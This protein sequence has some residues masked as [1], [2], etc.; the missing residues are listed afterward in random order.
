MKLHKIGLAVIGAIFLFGSYIFAQTSTGSIS[1][2]VEDESGA[3]VP[4]ANVIIKNV[5]T[6]ISR[7]AVTDAAG[8]YRV[9]G[10][11]PDHYEVQVTSE[12]F[13][14]AIR[15]GLQ[16]TVGS[17]LEINIVLKVGQV[18]QT[19]VVTAEASLVETMTGT[20]SGLVDDKAVRDLP[21]NG[22]SF[23]QL[24]GLQSSA[25][26][27]RLSAKT[28]ALG[29][30]MTTYSVNGAREQANSFFM[31]GTEVVGAGSITSLPGGALGINMGVDA[32]QEFSVLSSTYSAVY[33]KKSGGVI[34]I[35]TRSGSNQLHGSA[36]EFLRNSDLDARNFFD[37]K[38]PS[39][40]QNQ[41]GG[42]LG[43]P[44]RKDQTFYFGAYEGLRE[45][46]GQTN[47]EIVPDNNARQGLLPDLAHP[48]QFLNVGV[49]P[50][51]KPYLILF[52]PVN[53]R[54]FGD[55][56]AESIT[57][58]TL[59]SNQDFYL[60]RMDHRISDRDSLFGRYN[61][62]KSDQNLI[63]NILLFAAPSV[64]S[65]HLLT[66]QESRSYAT[67]LN[68]VRFGFN[69]S[70]TLLTAAPT[71]PTDPSLAFIPGAGGIGGINFSAINSG[72]G[73]GANGSLTTQG[74]G[75]AV[76]RY[77]TFNQ[78][79]YGDQ[80]F[81]QVGSHSLQLGVQIQRIQE[82]GAF[83]SSLWGV[84][85]FADLQTFLAGKPNLFTAASPYGG[86]PTKGYRLTYTGAYFQDDYKVLRN[87]TL[88]LGLRYEFLTPPT[89][90]SGNRISNFHSHIVNGLPVVDSTPTL[91]SPFYDS[92]RLNF[93]P[94]IGFAWDI[95]GDS[96]TA[97][98]GG[99]GTF[100]DQILNEF[101]NFTPNN[102]P[103]FG[104]LQVDNP[105]FPR[106]FSGATGQTPVPSVDTMDPHLAVPTLMGYNLNVQ[107]QITSSTAVTIGYVGSRGYHLTRYSELNTPRPQ[108][109]PGN[110]R[111]Y[112]S[113]APR[114]NPA[115]GA[116]RNVT[117]DA[118]SSY[119]SLQLEVT[120]HLSHG[121][122]YKVSLTYAKSIDSAS[123]LYTLHATGA[124]PSTQQ[125][126]ALNL[127]RGLSSFN[128]RRNLVMNWTYD[129]PWQQSSRA[130]ARW[131]GGWQLSGIVTLSD[132]MPFTALDGIN[133]SGDKA[134]NSAD[135]PNLKPGSSNNPVLG[136][137]D[138]YFD[139]SSFVIPP[140]GFY[141]NLGRNT[142]ISPG[143]ATFDCTLV[144]LMPVSE[145][146]KLDF[147]AEF[148]NLLNK[149]NFGLPR[150]TIFSGNGQAVAS[151]GRIGS[152]VS[153][154][155]QIQ[156]GL[157]LLF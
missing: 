67:T 79:E 85:Q 5:E 19:T 143:F 125:P 42:A 37:Q 128:V 144:K 116:N 129:L 27:V 24:I 87:L 82:N 65:S 108:I 154:S 63:S 133:R 97:V 104:L 91:G 39:F 71:I 106:G 43:G 48:G 34:N 148:F 83:P 78:F 107:R 73:A 130:M 21:L 152:T 95:F 13:E 20:L 50:Q 136:G 9:P 84:F 2:L 103:F 7:A 72:N 45:R 54:S 75:Q 69:R 35:A 46:L 149:A 76:G 111:F 110:V 36:F 140:V 132:G 96:K 17:D 153:T 26:V 93:A 15:K 131:V 33:G 146:V 62:S 56:S 57:N 51:V 90:A 68:T 121:L 137:P 92:H 18:S 32:I 47:T 52:P 126:D 117:S 66:L 53:G 138:K 49:A 11:I 40:K 77:F 134:Y 22:R 120:D 122:R 30:K 142:L 105:P 58:P 109:L 118:T 124:A 89:E 135:R 113:N 28:S 64:S 99:F 14:T 102:P 80:L 100:Y 127:D 3:V 61:F 141:G 112:P 119:N 98:R 38:I 139:A 74:S 145:R 88:N 44:I 70:H 101:I 60:A 29:G 59:A 156:L 6:G 123:T 16:L 41:F 1:G 25:A 86:D 81:H 147:R 94:R 10:L 155:R 23:D 151:A 157:K 4:G 55:G 12:G 8:R 31:D 115:L 114:L 150:N